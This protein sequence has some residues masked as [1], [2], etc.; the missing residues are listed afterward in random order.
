MSTSFSK[1]MALAI[2][3]LLRKPADIRPGPCFPLQRFKETYEEGS[4][5]HPSP[6]EEAV[7]PPGW[8]GKGLILHGSHKSG[9]WVARGS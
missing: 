2:L 5:I 1:D 7:L 8:G 3:G 6:R 4:L 9:G